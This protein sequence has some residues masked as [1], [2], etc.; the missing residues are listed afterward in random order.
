VFRCCS[1]GSPARRLSDLLGAV[2]LV[3]ALGHH[4]LDARG[5]VLAHPQPRHGRL[6]G[7][8]HEQYAAAALRG[9]V[10][11]V[12]VAQPGS[13]QRNTT[14]NKAAFALSQLVAAGLLPDALAR[15]SVMIRA[16]CS[17][18]GGFG[19]GRGAADGSAHVVGLSFTHPQRTAFLKAP[20]R[21]K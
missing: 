5:G 2:G 11:K 3:D 8:R 10:E 12:L 17:A 1:P 6:A 18:F 16:V 20:D 7:G 4:A 14:L 15:A 21:M 13:H 19:F 9:E